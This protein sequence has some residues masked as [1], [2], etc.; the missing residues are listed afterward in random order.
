M[1]ILINA[2]STRLGGGITVIRNLLP[3]FAAQDGG[4]NEYMVFCRDDVR[5]QLDTGAP[6]VQFARS[7][8][9]GRTALTRLLWEQVELSARAAFT[10]ADVVFSPANVAMLGC[11]RPQ[12]LMFQ[13]AAPFDADVVER[14]TRPRR[15]RFYLLRQLG[16]MSARV[17]KKVIF[18]S[19]FQQDLILPTLGISRE[20]ACRIYLGRDFSFGPSAHAG[21]DAVAGRL[22]IR[23]PYLLS[24]SQFY[25]YKNFVELVVGFARARRS[26]PDD[27]QLVIA[28]TEHEKDYS[29]L[30]RRTIVRE[31]VS[32]RVRLVGHVPYTDLPALYAGAE[33]FIFPSTCESFPNIFL[34]AMASGTPTLASNRASMRELGGDGAL[35]FDPFEPDQ[36]AM[37]IVQ[38]W[39]DKDA[40][41]G[42]RERG[43]A[44][45]LRYDWRETARQTLRV[46]EEAV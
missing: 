42:L 26:L 6:R 25:G 39:H 1:K 37:H 30:V 10:S 29:E 33:L 40:R 18:I 36:I 32:S 20:K 7:R 44:A 11:P 24:V 31:G 8:L 28:G 17:S 14:S 43:L 38:L 19:D 27:V 13:N 2:T 21:T 5:S 34:E 9:D 15:A 41:K 23:G 16:R 3:A 22:G 35:Y 45:C 12:V 4:R 46:F